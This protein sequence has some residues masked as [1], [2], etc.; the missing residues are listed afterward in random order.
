L[1]DRTGAKFDVLCDATDCR[2]TILNGDVLAVP[3]LAERLARSGISTLRLYL[4]GESPEEARRVL[5]SFRQALR[6]EAAED[7]KGRGYTKGHYF[8]EV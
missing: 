1:T 5:S 2:S 3:D 6:G 4:Y 8:R 7:L